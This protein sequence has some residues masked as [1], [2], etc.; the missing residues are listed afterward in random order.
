ML[1]GISQT[2]FLK[3]WG[4]PDTQIS[5]KKL[6]SLQQGTLYLSVDSEDDAYYSIWIYK[7]RDRVLFFA[8]KK[9]IVH[10]KWSGFDERHKQLREST[11]VH[12]MRITPAL[13]G[14]TLSLV[15]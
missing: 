6:G 4:E 15:A 13:V 7:E 11:G 8:K 9:L 1:A 5:L 12:G 10:F 2:L 14:K 3:N